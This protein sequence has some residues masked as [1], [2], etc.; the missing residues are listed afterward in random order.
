MNTSKDYRT[1]LSI[2]MKELQAAG[3]T[4][5]FGV[6][7][8]FLKNG[9]KIYGPDEVEIK[10]QFRFE[11]ESNPDDMSILYM[12]ETNDGKKGLLVDA[13]GVYADEETENF[14][15]EAMD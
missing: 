6:N 11:G 13:F 7:D 8:G 9:D 12:V 4:H 1:P 15:Q 10:G 5:S 3:Y 14:I 2:K